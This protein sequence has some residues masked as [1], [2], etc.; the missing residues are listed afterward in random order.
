MPTTPFEPFPR[1]SSARVRGHGQAWNT[2]ARDRC[3]G[4]EEVEGYR[5]T[6]P[7]SILER[8]VHDGKKSARKPGFVVATNTLGEHVWTVLPEEDWDVHLLAK[9]EGLRAT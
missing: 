6:R 8:L 7:L 4:Q 1:S 3:F 5:D 9:L 2:A